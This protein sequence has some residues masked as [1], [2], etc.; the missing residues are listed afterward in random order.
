M[1]LIPIPVDPWILF[2]FAAQGVFFLRF[3]VQWI[4]SEKEGKSVVPLAFWYLSISGALLILVYAIHRRD[5]VF[6]A[7]Q[8]LALV[9]YLRNIALHRRGAKGTYPGDSGS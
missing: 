6:I 4:V 8:G 7:G 2:G 3:F 9:I 1:S 5:P